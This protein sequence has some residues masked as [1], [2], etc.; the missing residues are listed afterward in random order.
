M[1]P[2]IVVPE[3]PGQEIRAK[4]SNLLVAYNESRTGPSG[5]ELLAV[6][7]Q[8]P[9]FSELM[10]GLWGRSVYGW[11]FV[12]FLFVPQELRGRGLGSALLK[13]AEEIA[14]RRG[15]VG[16]CLD[17]FDFQAPTFYRKFGYEYFAELESP[18]GGF[19]R[20]FL[21]KFLKAAG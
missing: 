1:T 15:C 10:G 13:R 16:V 11:L 14:I 20:H 3:H 21:R 4:L 9:D 2:S 17:S 5:F 18:N 7:L 19:K 6:I 12:E 8:D